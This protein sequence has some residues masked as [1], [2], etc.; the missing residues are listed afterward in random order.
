MNTDD[1]SQ[2]H[3]WEQTEDYIEPIDHEEE[4]TED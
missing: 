3:Y 1:I 2:V 4:P